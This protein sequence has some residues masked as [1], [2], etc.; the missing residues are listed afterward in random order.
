LGRTLRLTGI[1]AYRKAYF[2]ALLGIAGVVATYLVGQSFKFI[3]NMASDFLIESL[4]FLLFVSAF[5]L[6]RRYGWSLRGV[7]PRIWVAGS[8]SA[9]LVFTAVTVW[10]IYVY[11]GGIGFPHPS[12]VDLLL[13]LA[14]CLSIYALSLYIKAFKE[15]LKNE[16]VA[17]IRASLIFT[18]LSV[19]YF[20]IYP[21]VLV[22]IGVFEKFLAVVFILPELTLSPQPSQV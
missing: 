13:L 1:E 12:A 20:I 11:I 16:I 8:Y 6:A 15:A 4:A 17:V 10:N 21:I 3:L 5:L 19:A 9:M 7:I 2:T 14:L 18:S 22:E